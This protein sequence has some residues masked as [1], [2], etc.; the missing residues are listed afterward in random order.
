MKNTQ[1]FIIEYDQKIYDFSDMACQ[2]L[3]VDELHKIHLRDDIHRLNRGPVAEQ[4][5]VCRSALAEG[6]REFAE[7]YDAFVT[8]VIGPLYGG[9]I[10]YQR[11]PSFRFHYSGRGSSAFHRDRD[12]GVKCGRLNL[13]VPLTRVWGDNSLWIE[14]EEGAEDYTPTELD[15]GQAL[16]FDGANLKHGSKVNTTSSTRV[17]FDLRFAPHS[18]MA[19]GSHLV[20][21]VR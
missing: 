1:T 12:Y 20:L 16:I 21:L 9:I 11:P 5:E 19:P 10:S 14:S 4:I 6:F 15:Y 3:G 2:I 7:L 13:W 8:E 17:S 18:M